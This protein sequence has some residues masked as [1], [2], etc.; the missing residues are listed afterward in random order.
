M[1]PVLLN[2][3]YKFVDIGIA[4]AW[5][6]AILDSL[7]A[8]R[9]GC[10]AGGEAVLILELFFLKKSLVEDEGSFKFRIY[11]V[12][13]YMN[14]MST[15]QNFTQAMSGISKP[16]KKGICCLL[17]RLSSSSSCINCSALPSDK[18]LHTRRQ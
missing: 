16:K 3:V 13:I 1:D 11:T 17:P 5:N 4:F 9:F 14:K 15:Y 12:A 10:R 6:S 18:P 8:I 7:H 2:P